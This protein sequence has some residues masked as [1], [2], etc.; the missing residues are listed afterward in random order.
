MFVHP[1]ADILLVANRSN[2]A[3][4]C[5]WADPEHRRA[6][7]VQHG[8]GMPATSTL[9]AARQPTMS[10]S[11]G[12]QPVVES[13]HISWEKKRKGRSLAE[14]TRPLL[15]SLQGTSAAK[16]RRVEVERKKLT[17]SCPPQGKALSS[18]KSYQNLVGPNKLPQQTEQRNCSFPFFLL[19][20]SF[21]PVRCFGWSSF[22]LVFLK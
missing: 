2:E 21:F 11:T 4:H 15:S 3:E 12:T 22:G 1:T 20:L 13:F 5:D 10:R 17:R 14:A 9:T 18:R 16:R 8:A 7:F 19:E 6:A